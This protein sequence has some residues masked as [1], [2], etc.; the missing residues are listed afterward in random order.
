[1]PRQPRFILPGQPQHVI[2]RGN[3]R[4]TIF[5]RIRDYHFFL[6]VVREAALKFDCKIH[7]YVLMTNHVHFLITPDNKFGISKTMQSIGRR[8]VQ[9]FNK[10]YSR[11]GTL[12]EGRFKAALIDSEQYAL[13]CYRYIELN[14][15][16]AKMVDDPSDY[17]W[18]SYH[19]NA[20]GKPDQLVFPHEL[21]QRLGRTQAERCASYQKLFD[22]Q[23]DEQTLTNIRYATN[24]CWVLGE[25]KFKENAENQTCRPSSPQS[26]GGDRRSK[27]FNRV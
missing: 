17:R 11:T 14:P 24:R 12:W 5:R 19:K 23:L 9:Y 16:R 2:V 6:N 22:G 21:Y 4:I 7:A 20:E 8:Y 1:M 25:D 27:P 15:V 18:S 26:R 10:S 3:N 13:T